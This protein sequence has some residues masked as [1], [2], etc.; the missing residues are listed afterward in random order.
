MLA[1]VLKQTTK[2]K[3]QQK[4][5]IG[6]GLESLGLKG[7][8]TIHRNLTYEDLAT[9]EKNNNEGTF[10]EAEYG[11][12]FA[13]DT[14]TLTLPSKKIFIKSQHENRTGKF[15][16]R[17]PKDKWIV[18]QQPSEDNFWWGEVNQPMESEVFDELYEKCVDHYN[19]LDEFYLFDGFCGANPNSR[20]RVRFLT[21]L[22]WQQHFVRNMFIRPD[23]KELEV[24]SDPEYTIINA[25]KVVDE[26]WQKH[27]LNSEVFVA[28]NTEKKVAIIGGTWYVS[29]VFV[30]YIT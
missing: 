1:R 17:S 7:E 10:V 16:G 25:C 26:D 19:N 23:A 24:F 5:F 13:V 12:T 3:F 20:K 9:H 28:F 14:G 18:K 2:T 21:E 22:A 11:N 30:S 6:Y 29:F 15:T 27:K 8:P 4:R